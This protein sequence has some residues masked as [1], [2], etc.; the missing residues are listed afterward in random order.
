MRKLGF[1]AVL[2]VALFA[3]AASAQTI[4]TGR[5]PSKFTTP[6]GQQVDQFVE[7][8]R[9]D[10]AWSIT[11]DVLGIGKF[12]TEGV[13]LE[14]DR[15]VFSFKP[16]PVVVCVLKKQENGDYVGACTDDG[17]GVAPMSMTPPK[18]AATP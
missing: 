4:Q 15:L 2:A 13:K 10:T 1:M 17:G 16:G 14:E 9:A 6:D 12:T 11:L 18:E 7:I 3:P 8:A 5:W